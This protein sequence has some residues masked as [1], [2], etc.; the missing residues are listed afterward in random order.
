MYVH[1]AH[2]KYNCVCVCVSVYYVYSVCVSVCVLCVC[3]VSVWSDLELTCWAEEENSSQDSRKP[4]N[5]SSNCST[6]LST[7]TNC[8]HTHN[9]KFHILNIHSIS[10]L[11]VPNVYT[12]TCTPVLCMYTLPYPLNYRHI[13]VKF[14]CI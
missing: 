5:L 9:S 8:A 12:T 13:K 1:H 11:R 7:D 2:I 3:G 14:H 4:G 10:Q 6:C